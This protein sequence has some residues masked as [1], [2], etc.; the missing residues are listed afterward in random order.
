MVA[1]CIKHSDCL[2]VR[3]FGRF[4]GLYDNLDTDSL[5]LYL[6]CL[7]FI[8][9]KSHL[10]TEISKQDYD[11]TMFTPLV[12]ALECVKSQF[13]GKLN[14][15]EYFAFRFQIENSKITDPKKINK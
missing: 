2:R 13:E 14:T 1:S 4:L 7:D 12:R 11:E 3:N 6:D 9:R 8:E 5:N 15:D 10:G